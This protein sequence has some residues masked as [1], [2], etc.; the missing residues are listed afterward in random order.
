MAA[1]AANAPEAAADAAALMMS[2]V[3][4]ELPLA[5]KATSPSLYTELAEMYELT[6]FMPSLPMMRFSAFAPAPLTAVESPTP[7]LAANPA[8]AANA[9]TSAFSDA[10]RLIFSVGLVNAFSHSAGSSPVTRLHLF[11]FV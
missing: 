8:P 3:I 1:L 7:K 11:S 10:V 2:E 5:S 6:L 9:L 4:F